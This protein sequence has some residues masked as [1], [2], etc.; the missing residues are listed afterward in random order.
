[1]NRKRTKIVATI[2]DRRCE[3]EF[4]RT[5]YEAG[6]NAI[7]INSAHVTTES[8]L[9]IIENG[10]RI[11]EKIPFLLDTKG[12]EIRTTH[13]DAPIVM[14]KGQKITMMGDPDAK[15]SPACIFVNYAGFVNDVP[16]GS[17]ILIDDGDVELIIESRD[18]NMLHCVASNDGT[19]GSRKSVN[20]PKV[21]FGLPSVSER[22]REFLEFAA[23]HDIDFIA[24]SFVRRRQDVEDV[25]AILD[26]HGS[27]AKI[28]AKIENQEGVDNIDDI[29]GA[30]YGIMVARGDLAIE[31]PYEKIPGIQK[32]IIEKCIE[33]R[34][35]VIVATQMLHSMIQNPRPTRAEVSDIANAIYSQTDALMLSGETASGRYAEEAV[36]VMTRVA[37]EAES[38]KER[39]I[40][41]PAG[42]MT[43]KVSA[44]LAKVAV[45]TSLRIGARA[46]IADTARGR[47]IRNM[48][49]FR[50]YNLILAQCYSKRTMR[51]L[52]ISYG[53]YTSFLEKKNSVDDF[54][55][56]ALHEMTN[57]HDL[58]GEDIVVVLAGNFSGGRGFSFIE[59]G[60]VDY[61][62]GRVA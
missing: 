36:K 58:S 24:H 59:V 60:T 38:N 46:L 35:P 2:S 27:E 16:D 50:G 45:K 44:Y 20:V 5:L 49:A 23:V 21:N 8:A 37:F 62:K 30:V 11:S 57:A 22:D 52:A 18:G 13:C 32:M 1:M 28:I 61:L 4:I 12:P 6:M 41:M 33:H 53:V 43:G 17:S 56:R 19:I 42:E 51:E 39:Y 47:T 3:P 54:I 55:R 10:R 14:T 29:L 15:S 25:Q 34:K 48:A 31:I 26:S 40:E 9:K 7:R